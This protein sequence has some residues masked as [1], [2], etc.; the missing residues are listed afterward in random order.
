TVVGWITVVAYFTAAYM[1][2]RAARRV[3]G[4]TFC[5]TGTQLYWLLMT[6]GLI[7]LGFNKQLDLQT[8]FTLFFKHVALREG[9]YE[10]RRPVQAAF[11]AAVGGGGAMSLVGLRALAGKATRAVLVGLAGSVFLGC[12]ILIRASSFHHVDQ[13]LGMNFEGFKLNWILELGGV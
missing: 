5:W 3:A 8:W 7:L 9:W 6:V 2:W 10:K 13:M 4:N 1:C 11:I 12:F